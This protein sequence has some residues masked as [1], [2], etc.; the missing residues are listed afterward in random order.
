M[1]YTRHAQAARFSLL[2]LIHLQTKQ[3]FRK[4]LKTK[5]SQAKKI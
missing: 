5:I 4:W 2:D 3:K 1:E